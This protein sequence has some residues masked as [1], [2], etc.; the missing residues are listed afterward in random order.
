MIQ[1]IQTIYLLLT[2]VMC[3]L[4]L[5]MTQVIFYGEGNMIIKISL[6]GI[7]VA[8]DSDLIFEGSSYLLSVPFMLTALLSLVS[9]FLFKSRRV[10]I[11][12]VKFAFFLIIAG[13]AVGV[14]FVISIMNKY[15]A[16]PVIGI[17]MLLPL[18]VL[19]F[20]YLAYRGIKKDDKLVKSYDRIR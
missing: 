6:A 12:L 19:A 5:T 3:V 7:Y 16:K 14:Y 4:F 15:Q 2:T 20:L 17:G 9:I 11:L 1:R 8:R 13:T 18:F 10:Q